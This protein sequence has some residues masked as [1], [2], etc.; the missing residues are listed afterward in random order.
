MQL[1][2]RNCSFCSCSA[3]TSKG[4]GCK[5]AQLSKFHILRIRK[6]YQYSQEMTNNKIA[7][8]VHTPTVSRI[9][10][11]GRIIELVYSPSDRSTKLAVWDGKEAVLQNEVEH[12]KDE[13]L[14]PIS[15][16]NNLI[17]HEA[18]V[19]PEKSEPYGSTAELVEE[20]GRY[21]DR[22]VVLSDWFRRVA[23]Y[24]VLSTWVYDAFQEIGYLRLQADW[25]SGKTRALMVI[26]SICQKGY[27]ASGAST[28]SPIFHGLNTFR[29]TLILDE[30]DFRFSDLTAELCKIL[31]NGTVQ[32]FPVL[33]TA[34]TQ[35]N[36]FDP[37]AFHVFG[38]KIVAMRK[39]FDDEALESR[40]ITE[41]MDTLK[42]REGIPINLPPEQKEEARRLRNMLLQYRF[43]NRRK[44]RP[45]LSLVEPTLSPRTNQM[46]VPLLS[47][48]D[49]PSE[50]E[51]ICSAMAMQEK[52]RVAARSM[53]IEAE[54]VDVLS[55][56][57]IGDKEAPVGISAITA[58]LID[59][60]AR[61]YDRPITP[62]YVGSLLR[63][64]LGLNTYKS[65]GMY[66]V[67][68][69][70]TRLETLRTRYG[71]FDRTGF[72]RNFGVQ[73]R[74]RCSSSS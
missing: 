25:G 68:V 54:L 7:K 66:V 11:D 24:Y 6:G 36:E 48:V 1:S 21:F 5:D 13:V 67:V 17:R 45:D 31:N 12:T 18:I 43:D 50:R 22:Y 53:S 55:E 49:L 35:K 74:S 15:A 40:F 16:T 62:R 23:A 28:V 37:R 61:N 69:D 59:R 63:S 44:V 46:L 56:L 42:L 33:R 64:R 39:S 10:P 52:E 4:E 72:Q 9:L 73:R 8:Q 38:P 27:F 60:F 71:T 57:S 20:I 29:G 47:V 30:A 51:A 14:L 32:G 26:G 3:G 70:P 58:G 2:A 19:L 65:N 34:M 41:R